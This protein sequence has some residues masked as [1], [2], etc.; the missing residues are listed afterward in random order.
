MREFE[1]LKLLISSM[2]SSLRSVVWSST[3]SSLPASLVSSLECL[4]RLR[5][6]VHSFN[7]CIFAYFILIS[8]RACR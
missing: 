7:G 1:E 6:I 5:Y 8:R 4:A 3:R 2:W